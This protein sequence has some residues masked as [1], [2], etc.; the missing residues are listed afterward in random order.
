[1]TTSGVGVVFVSEIVQTGFIAVGMT[2]ILYSLFV[3]QTSKWKNVSSDLPTK[4]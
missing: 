3:S 4:D 1:M 2:L